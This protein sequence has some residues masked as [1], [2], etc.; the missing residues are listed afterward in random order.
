MIN[1][2]V[3]FL[4]SVSV[5]IWMVIILIAIAVMVIVIWVEI[6]IQIK[7]EEERSAMIKAALK[8]D[9]LRAARF[10]SSYRGQSLDEWLRNDD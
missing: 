8:A 5:E 2:F 10:I 9:A 6:Y 4:A 7:N 3:S 1:P